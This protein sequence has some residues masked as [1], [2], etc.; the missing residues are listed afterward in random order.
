[1][2]HAKKSNATKRRYSRVG[3][4]NEEGWTSQSA[5]T[6]SGVAGGASREA[7]Q[8]G[9]VGLR[10]QR[11][12]NIQLAETVAGERGGRVS[13]QAAVRPT[14]K[15]GRSILPSAGRGD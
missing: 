12:D 3:N 2:G 7:S 6:S 9:R 8:G 10:G 14:A 11:S 13:Q 15:G 5:A 1:M 4:R